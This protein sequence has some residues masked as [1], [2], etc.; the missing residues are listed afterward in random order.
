MG[1]AAAE[2]AEDPRGWPPETIPGSAADR[3]DS[4]AVRELRERGPGAEDLIQSTA[5]EFG[6]LP[7]QHGLPSRPGG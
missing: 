2:T 3:P 6:K 7:K 1:V 4:P 5:A